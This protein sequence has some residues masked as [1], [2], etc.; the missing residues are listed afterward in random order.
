MKRSFGFSVL[1]PLLAAGCAKEVTPA[2]PPPVASAPE[3]EPKPEPEPE[4]EP[5]KVPEDAIAV[6]TFNLEWAFDDIDT[7]P[8]RA[9]PHAAKTPEDWVWKRDRIVEILIAERLDV[10]T[11]SE[12]GGE[13]ELSDIA[14]E[15]RTKGGYDYDTAWMEGTDR[16]TGQ[17]V[18]VLSRFRMTNV[19]RYDVRIKKHVAVD[20]ELPSGDPI[21]VVAVHLREGQ[22]PAYSAKRRKSVRALNLAIA[23]EH[24]EHP[25]LI[26]GTTNSRVS[27]FDDDYAKRTPG[28]LAHRNNRKQ[29]DDCFDSARDAGQT[30]I[31]GYPSDHI[32]SCGLELRAA[33][34]SAEDKVL[35]EDEDPS[36]LPWP[37][38]P[39]E[40][41]PYRDVSDHFLVWAEIALP[42]RPPEEPATPDPMARLES[43][44]EDRAL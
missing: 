32:I 27:T 24:L 10:V 41:A 42:E 21:T 29:G 39:I 31:K 43:G 18:A 3:P 14:Y 7:R 37:A 44:R 4:I 6:G 15:V 28:I 30:T 16:A 9:Q 26:L 25:V 36:E 8:K 11:L 12:L 35:R 19:R 33:Y 13:R 38:V 34:A 5:P 20:V 23:R 40:D 1:V 17:Q 22:A 2:Q